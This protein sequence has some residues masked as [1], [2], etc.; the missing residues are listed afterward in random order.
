MIPS[1][2]VMV[3]TGSSALKELTP[4]MAGK[5]T[6]LLQVTLET[7]FSMVVPAMTTYRPVMAAIR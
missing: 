4:C 2:A 6:T 5:G 1:S 3:T 7:T